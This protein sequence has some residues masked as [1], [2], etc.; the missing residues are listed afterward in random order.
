MRLRHRVS[1]ELEPELLVVDRVNKLGLGAVEPQNRTSISL[2]TAAG[3]RYAFDVLNWSASRIDALVELDDS[4]L[5]VVD[6]DVVVDAT[7]GVPSTEIS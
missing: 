4:R 3:I 5:V 6:E 2:V 1:T 7:I